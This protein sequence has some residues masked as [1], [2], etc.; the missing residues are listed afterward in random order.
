MKAECVDTQSKAMRLLSLDQLCMVLKFALQRLKHSQVIKSMIKLTIL[1][2]P[3]VVF[4][5]S[6][7][8]IE[9]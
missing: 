4:Q 5:S 7:P 8:T 1:H 2:N 9:S 6:F 3:Q